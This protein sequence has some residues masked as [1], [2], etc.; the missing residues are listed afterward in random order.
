MDHFLY[1]GFIVVI[2]AMG[3]SVGLLFRF[4]AVFTTN[5]RSNSYKNEVEITNQKQCINQFIYFY[6]T[7]SGGFIAFLTFLDFTYNHDQIYHLYTK[8]DSF[9]V[10]LSA[11]I[12]FLYSSAMLYWAEGLRLRQFFKQQFFDK[13]LGKAEQQ[14]IQYK[15]LLLTKRYYLYTLPATI[16]YSIFY[17]GLGSVSLSYPLIIFINSYLI[18][19]IYKGL[20]Y[21]GTKYLTERI[22]FY[23]IIATIC[24]IILVIVLTLY[25]GI[26]M[27]PIFVITTQGIH[28][29]LWSGVLM[30]L[31]M[32]DNAYIHYRNSVID[33]LTGVYNR[34]YFSSELKKCC[35]ENDSDSM[36][37][38][39][40]FDIDNFKRINDNYGHGVGDMALQ[41]FVRVLQL[42]TC[43]GD[44]VARVGGEEFAIILTD[45]D[46]IT[47]TE[48]AETICLQLYST[49]MT[50]DDLD[51]DSYNDKTKVTITASIGVAVTGLAQLNSVTLYKY[52]DQAMYQSKQSGKNRVTVHESCYEANTI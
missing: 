28:Y 50:I 14:K 35:D 27:Y 19:L 45:T 25:F 52:A 48:L 38:L 24:S 20:Q 43:D 4:V 6:I 40:V 11:L 7:C 36:T 9:H 13:Q 2:L 10:L 32:S 22:I 5:S 47:A 44:I 17:I 16:I 37:S 15:N 18:F 34:R 29:L 42:Y 30:F 8:N 49:P 46:L 31:I 26:E 3:I 41:H 33:A 39:L 23:L 1:I 12:I 21:V 51:S